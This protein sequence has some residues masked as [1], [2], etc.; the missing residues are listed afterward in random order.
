MITRGVRVLVQVVQDLALVDVH[1]V[2]QGHRLGD[3]QTL[4]VQTVQENIAKDPALSDDRHRTGDER[5]VHDLHGGETVGG[6]DD[7]DTVGSD[8]PDTVTGSC[9]LRLLLQRL[10]LLPD[11][12]ETGALDDDVF[13]PP[14]PYLGQGLRHHRGGH[15]DHRQVGSG[16]DIGYSLMQRK[17][18][19]LPP[20]GVDQVN[21]IAPPLALQ[22]Q[23]E[24]ESKTRRTP[25][26]HDNHT[27]GGE[28]GTE[29]RA[30]HG[31][32]PRRHR[33]S[34]F[35]EMVPRCCSKDLQTGRERLIRR[36]TRP[37][38]YHET[39]LLNLPALTCN[40]PVLSRP[41]VFPVNNI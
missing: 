11:L 1:A 39:D 22:G 31:M 6:V 41:P 7:P 13:Y 36:D 3:V 21:A 32:T 26:P 4:L 18:M 34:A 33:L 12:S 38:I 29:V 17:A 19:Q 23:G 40:K 9:L 25:R 20:S 16:R 30:R 28:E 8:D 37:L 10:S 35:P 24:D 27:L 5:L 15:D 14:F 2:A